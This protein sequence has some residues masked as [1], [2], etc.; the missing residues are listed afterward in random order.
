MMVIV[1]TQATLEKAPA[2]VH[3]LLTNRCNL[4]CPRCF[5]RQT[6]SEIPIHT[7]HRL[8]TEWHAKGVKAVAIGGGEPFLYPYI[9]ETIS[10]AKRL[11]FYLAITTNGTVL[12]KL[13]TP[14]DRVHISHD[15]I[16][17]TSQSDVEKALKHFK[18][19]RVR[20]VGIN[21]VVTT[22]KKAKATLGLTCDNVTLLVEKPT[23]QFQDWKALTT[24]INANPEKVW[25]DACLA[26][27]LNTLGLM[28][29]D[30]PCRQGIYSMSL[31]ADLDA[32]KCSNVKQ[33]IAYTSIENTWQ[34]VRT[35]KGC[36]MDRIIN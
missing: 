7:I 1:T 24:L 6:K 10:A 2:T 28:H 4:N 25:L 14:P 12:P 5:Y 23:S 16:H 21:H 11:G 18:R 33:P 34:A 35:Q 15:D 26:K 9:N 36:L 29:F 19:E 30:M 8:F 13:S 27:L 17:S 20:R 22:V 31:N 32:S 3:L